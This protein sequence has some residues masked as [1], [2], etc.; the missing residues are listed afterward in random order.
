MPSVFEKLRFRKVQRA[1]LLHFFCMHW[2]DIVVA[3]PS[4]DGG[5][6][7]VVLD[8]TCIHRHRGARRWLAL[9]SRCAPYGHGRRNASRVF[10]VH[11]GQERYIRWSRGSYILWPRT[12]AANLREL[13]A[14]R[15]QLE[16][17][18]CAR[19]TPIVPRSA[20]YD[21]HDI[22]RNRPALASLRERLVLPPKPGAKP[23]QA[24]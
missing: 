14:G 12:V 6:C 8:F 7:V 18:R 24:F 9:I 5:A 4:G 15:R 16:E 13:R 20:C 3:L 22:R 23:R 1:E 21:C 2:A 10:F 11:P 19:A 17:L